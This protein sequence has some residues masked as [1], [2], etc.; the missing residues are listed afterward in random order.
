METV[1]SLPI[2][3]RLKGKALS[4]WAMRRW[5]WIGWPLLVSLAIGVVWVLGMMFIGGSKASYNVFFTDHL[6]QRLPGMSQYEWDSYRTDQQIKA[7]LFLIIISLVSLILLG[8]RI[9][10]RINRARQIKEDQ[11]KAAL[12]RE[13]NRGWRERMTQ[14]QSMVYRAIIHGFKPKVDLP[15][16]PSGCVRV[17]YVHMNISH[18]GGYPTDDRCVHWTYFPIGS[19][20]WN[21]VGAPHYKLLVGYPWRLAIMDV[22]YTIRQERSY[23]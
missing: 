8:C 1:T 7:G 19:I 14:E 23:W 18:P 13:Y 2:R 12:N 15:E 9:I 16:V 6:S 3:Q 4:L 17:F 20:P 11:E 21:A 10:A 5:S 22:M